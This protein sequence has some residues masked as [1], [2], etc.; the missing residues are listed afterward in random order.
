MQQPF[1]N[2]A[3]RAFLEQINERQVTNLV[4]AIEFYAD[5]SPEVATWLRQLSKEEVALL[6]EGIKLVNSGKTVGRFFRRLL[7][8]AIAIFLLM[9]QFGDALK[10]LIASWKGLFS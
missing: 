3:A 7:V 9:T 1:L 5:L 10:K 4:E 2:Q 6:S 8:G